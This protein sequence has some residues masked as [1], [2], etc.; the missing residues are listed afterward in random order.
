MI[1]PC[2]DCKNKDNCRIWCKDFKRY[3]FSDYEPILNGKY[4]YSGRSVN[5]DEYKD[6]VTVLL[7]QRQD[8]FYRH[9]I[10][11]LEKMKIRPQLFAKNQRSKI[12]RLWERK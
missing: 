9:E 10:R 3:I 11:W 2:P 4:A 7:S 1:N 6:M 12:V 5:N 8:R